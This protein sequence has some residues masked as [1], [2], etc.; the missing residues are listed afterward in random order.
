VGDW[1]R[2]G[3]IPPDRR[4]PIP[5]INPLALAFTGLLLGGILWALIAGGPN[6]QAR[7]QSDWCG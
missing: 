4:L 2:I 6:V 3:L 5:N 7:W 1:Q